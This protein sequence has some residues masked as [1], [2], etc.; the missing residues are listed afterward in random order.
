MSKNFRKEIEK[1]QKK[2]KFG[3]PFAL[4]RFSDG[5]AMI[6][7]DWNLELGEQIKFGTDDNMKTHN[8]AYPKEDHKKYNPKKDSWFRDKLLESF[9]HE[10]DGYY[11][12]IHTG[13]DELYDLQFDL[14]KKSKEEVTVDEHYTFSDVFVNGNYPYFLEQLMPYFFNYDVSIICN[15]N[16]NID[17]LP[18]KVKKDFR[19]GYNCM[20]NNYDIIEDIK[21]YIDDNNIENQLFLFSASALSETAI[22]QLYSHCDKNTYL[23]IGTCLN[24]FMDITIDRAYLR[25]FW[26]ASGEPDIT[27]MNEW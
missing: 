16:A 7:A 15:E 20:I 25:A 18:F 27:R 8:Y 6:L 2:L 26:K 13:R 22:H 4:T 23:D 11:K 5:E 1:F 21:K 3:E 24:Y 17:S 14:L 9:L 12:G 10:Q 19:V